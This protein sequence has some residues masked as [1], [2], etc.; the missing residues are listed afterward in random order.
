MLFPLR[1]RVNLVV[2]NVISSS[3]S[4]EQATP[5]CR[6]SLRNETTAFSGIVVWSRCDFPNGTRITRTTIRLTQPASAVGVSQP[7]PTRIPESN[8]LE[9]QCLRAKTSCKNDSILAIRIMKW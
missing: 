4:R 2:N 5:S 8:E 9:Q 3:L 1:L 6:C 7:A